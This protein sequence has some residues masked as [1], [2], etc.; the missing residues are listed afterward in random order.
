MLLGVVFHST[1]A[2]KF[3]SHGG[4][5]PHDEQFNHWIFDLSGFFIHSFRMPLFFL[6]A[7]YFCRFLYYKIGEHK[8]ILH[9]W[10]RVGIPFF[11]GLILIVPLSLFPCFMYYNMYLKGLGWD[12]AW[13]NSFIRMF[14]LNGTYH[15]WFLY[16]LLMYYTFTVIAMRINRISFFRDLTSRFSMWWSKVSFA[17][18]FWPVILSVPAWFILFFN[19]DLFVFVDVQFIPKHISYI[20]FYGYF[21]GLGW[22]LEKRPDAFAVLIKNRALFICIGTVVSLFLFY[23]EWNS[24]IYRQ[25]IWW[26]L[27]KFAACFQVTILSLGFIG[28]FLHYFK[29]E[30]YFWRYVSDASYWVYLTHLGLVVWLQLLFLDSNIPGVFRF[31]LVLGITVLITFA[32]YQWFVRYT[33]IGNILHGPRTR[34]KKY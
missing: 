8:F 15:L 26:H 28:F 32:T 10:K 30:S 17:G 23:A 19:K 3:K 6:I 5:Q 29:A 13:K 24:E 34:R 11:T 25:T 18:K 7:G 12:E 14:R 22:L 31:P 21:F 27:A 16:D 9:R 1:L 20:L 2:Y 4:Y 33:F